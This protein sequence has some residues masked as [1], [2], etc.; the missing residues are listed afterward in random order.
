MKYFFLF[1]L[2]SNLIVKLYLGL[3]NNN[4]NIFRIQF[5]TTTLHSKYVESVNWRH[6]FGLNKGFQFDLSK[7]LCF[8]LLV[9]FTSITS[10]FI[11]K[12]EQ[13]L[14]R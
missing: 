13:L 14:K 8:A 1:I 2:S 3:V 12:E 6:F 5:I 10:F 11:H 4:N 7:W 9:L